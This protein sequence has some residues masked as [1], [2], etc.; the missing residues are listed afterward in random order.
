M[1]LSR[2]GFVLI[3]MTLPWPCT[4]FSYDNSTFRCRRLQMFFKIGVLQNFAIFTGKHLCWS[5]FLINL[6]GLQIYQKETPTQVLSWEYCKNL[7]IF[8][9]NCLSVFDHFVGLALKELK[10]KIK[11]LVKLK[12]M[13]CS[14][15]FFGTS[16]DF[17]KSFTIVMVLQKFVFKSL[18]TLKE[19]CFH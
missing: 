7:W 14:F 19:M 16:K 6:Q 5:I 11:Y 1:T 2:Y 8:P 18:I 13:Q 17:M 12:F 9:T 15:T 10:S 4:A 3:S